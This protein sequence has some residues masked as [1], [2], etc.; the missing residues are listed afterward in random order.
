M[1]TILRA[2]VLG[3]IPQCGPRLEAVARPVEKLQNSR[4]NLVIIL[5]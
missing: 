1:R 5:G 2:H 3:S 4:E